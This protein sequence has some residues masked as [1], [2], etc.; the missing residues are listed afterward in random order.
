MQNGTFAT[1][2]DNK[3]LGVNNWQVPEWVSANIFC[4]WHLNGNSQQ[5][6]EEIFNNIK[7]LSEASAIE[8]IRSFTSLNLFEEAL[9]I[10]KQLLDKFQTKLLAGQYFEALIDFHVNTK[11]ISAIECK[12]LIEK[13]FKKNEYPIIR[14][15]NLSRLAYLTGNYAQ[16]YQIR[17]KLY[18][19]DQN[20]AE[21]AKLYINSAIS[22]GKTNELTPIIEELILQKNA[23]ADM[24]FQYSELKETK[25]PKSVDLII[26]NLL[27]SDLRKEQS[28]LLRFSAFNIEHKKGKFQKAFQFLKRANDDRFDILKH[29]LAADFE[30]IE[31]CST[32]LID[33]SLTHRT[34]QMENIIQYLLLVSP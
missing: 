6:V 31:R 22:V 5:I 16:A 11:K 17:K 9:N 4:S 2:V 12:N 7:F 19:Q 3:I 32:F 20:N 27:D 25:V 29:T 34:F 15:L 23:S 30:H 10:S 1:F 26:Q 21:L 24:I 28:S 14:D 8:A 33:I 13:F 18:L